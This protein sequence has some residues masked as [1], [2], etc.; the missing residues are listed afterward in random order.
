[1]TW[2]D[3][4][5]SSDSNDVK[6]KANKSKAKSSSSE[7]DSD[8]DDD[9]EDDDDED[10]DDDD[11]NDNLSDDSDSDTNPFAKGSDSDEG[12]IYHIVHFYEVFFELSYLLVFESLLL[13]VYVGLSR[14]LQCNFGQAIISLS[15]VLLGSVC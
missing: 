9:D 3:E 15:V 2:D 7:E 12:M 4:A 5:E 8:N 14:K 10:E 6:P 11:D 13:S 1:M